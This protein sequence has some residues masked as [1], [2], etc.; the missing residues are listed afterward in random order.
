M[1]TETCINYLD[2]VSHECDKHLRD[3]QV[4]DDELVNLIIEFQRFQE[5]TMQSELP[6]EIKN[7]ISEIKLDYSIKG[8]ERG[9]WYLMV[10]FLTFGSWA[11][12]IH[13]KKQT[14]RKQALN[15][16]KFDASRLSSFI[17]FNY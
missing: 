10:A 5:K 7:K 1:S 4:T 17:K 11:I 15:L 14:K 3:N 2:F 9:N 16:L 13:M 8:V 6:E 12:F